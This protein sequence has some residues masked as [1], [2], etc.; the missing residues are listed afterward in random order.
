MMKWEARLRSWLMDHMLVLAYGAVA[1]LGRFLRFSL[2]P[3]QSDDLVYMNA[4]WFEAIKAEGMAGILEPSLEYTYSPL[5]LYVWM[6]AAALFGSFDTHVVLKLVSIAFEIG[7]IA[8]LCGL[9]RTLMP[10]KN[11]RFHRFLGFSALCLNPVLLW[12]AAGWGQ[13]D[14]MFA[15]FAVLAVWMLMKD[16]PVWGLVWLGVSLGFKLQA[17]FLLP[18]FMMAY[19]CGRKRFSVLW[20]LLVPG[21]LVA[22][23]IPMMLVGES[24]LFAVNIYLGQTDLYS[25]ITYNY[26]NLYAIM[27]EALEVDQMIL[28]MHSRVG[29]A[30]CIAALGAVAAYLMAFRRQLDHPSMVLLGAWC[31]LCCV[32]FLPRMHERYAI[33]GELLLICWALWTCKPRAFLYVL[34][35]MAPVLSAYSEYLFRKPFFSLQLGGVM[36]LVLLA[37]LSWEVVTAL[38]NAPSTADRERMM[39]NLKPEEEKEQAQ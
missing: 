2:L 5:H 6:L 19:F 24:P 31:V 16:R 33:V 12:N 8:A 35:S 32:F 25:R 17:I 10:G 22:S 18:L 14:A 28:G 4:S 30:L 38:R 23:G 3:M 29:M 13:T 1:L 20:F 9:M 26:P 15:L 37:L 34:L 11:R 39:M 27:G 7:L 21:I 36:N